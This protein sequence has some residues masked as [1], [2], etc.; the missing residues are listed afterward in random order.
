[1]TKRGVESF[2]GL[3]LWRLLEFI[4]CLP[5]NSRI[6]VYVQDARS[7]VACLPIPSW[8][9]PKKQMRTAPPR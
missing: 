1:M 8:G 5:A 4:E 3:R 6:R 9:K 2:V 7:L